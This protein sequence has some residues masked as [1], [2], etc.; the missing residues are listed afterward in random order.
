MSC[1]M[2]ST[3]SPGAPASRRMRGAVS[4]PGAQALALSWEPTAIPT[5]TGCSQAYHAMPYSLS[6]TQGV[7]EM[8]DMMPQRLPL[9]VSSALLRWQAAGCV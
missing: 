4:S 8:K 3:W 6:R 5:S 2:G 9:M 1:R 7:M